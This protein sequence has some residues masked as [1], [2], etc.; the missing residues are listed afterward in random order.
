M[1][2]LT[3]AVAKAVGNTPCS[4]RELAHAADVD[5]SLFWRILHGERRAS[6]D[7][8]RRVAD[9]LREW[10]T[11]CSAAADAIEG[12]LSGNEHG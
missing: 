8:A 10:A 3:A 1:D 2:E 11:E 9:A 5:Y 4:L 12:Y 7:V 6:P